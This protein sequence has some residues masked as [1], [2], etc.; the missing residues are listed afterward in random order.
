MSGA[1]YGGPFSGS[2]FDS[3]WTD[4]S[5]IVRPT[6]DGIHGR[7]YINTSVDIGRKLPHLAFEDGQLTVEPPPLLENPL[8]VMFDV[9]PERFRRGAV[10]A[11][12]RRRRRGD[13]FAR[14]P[15]ARIRDFRN[16]RDLT[17]RTSTASRTTSSRSGQ[18]RRHSPGA[19]CGRHGDGAR[20]RGRRGGSR[21]AA[22]KGIPTR[23]SRFACRPRRRLR[24][25]VVRLTREG[26]RGDPPGFRQ[27]RSR[28][29]AVPTPRHMRDV[30][31][32]V[33]GVL[34]KDGARDLVTLIASGGIALAEH[35]AKAVICGADLVAIDLPLLVALE[36]RLCGECERG[37]SRSTGRSARSRWTTSTRRSPFAASST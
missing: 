15:R 2:G 7:E 18:R 3:M 32:E 8:P 6:R 1:G 19:C 31:R 16:P 21:F 14:H 29:P 22:K 24:Q 37:E 33:H 12:D 20:R 10:M 30:L 5:E 26:R 13:R 11:V 25:R 4:M 35:V 9:I 36:C 27:A 34:V 17:L 28:E 23:S